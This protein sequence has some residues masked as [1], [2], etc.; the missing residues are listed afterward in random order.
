MSLIDLIRPRSV[1]VAR[2]AAEVPLIRRL[3]DAIERPPHPNRYVAP[4]LRTVDAVAFALR[5][6]RVFWTIPRRTED[7]GP[8]PGVLVY[9]SLRDEPIYSGPAIELPTIIPGEVHRVAS[10]VQ[11]ARV[12]G[13]R[14]AFWQVRRE[15]QFILQRPRRRR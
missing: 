13:L 8:E 12:V 4:R 10:W 3:R 1:G 7:G 14:F 9:V 2:A 15:L 6:Y 5:G 11:G